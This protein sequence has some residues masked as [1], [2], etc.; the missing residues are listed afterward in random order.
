MDF[1]KE[2]AKKKIG[3]YI[4]RIGISSITRALFASSLKPSN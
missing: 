1:T 3:I 4:I 2:Q